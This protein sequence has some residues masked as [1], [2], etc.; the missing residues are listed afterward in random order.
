MPLL[1]PTLHLL[2]LHVVDNGLFITE[3][4]IAIVESE[5][6][7]YD[8]TEI[9]F[10]STGMYFLAF[11]ENAYISSLTYGSTTIHQLDEK[12]IPESVARKTATIP[13][14]ATASVGQYIVVSAVDES[15]KVTATEAV[16]VTDIAEVSY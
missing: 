4:W 16:T 15:G 2:S 8:D 3:G 10:P 6:V 9:I 13:M 7:V 11:N 14:P 1:M 5:T 12:F